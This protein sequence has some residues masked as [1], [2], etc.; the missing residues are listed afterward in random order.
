MKLSEVQKGFFV[1]FR[2]EANAKSTIELYK[3]F[4]GQLT[5]F[6]DDPEIEKISLEDLQEYFNYLLDEYVPVRKN[7]DISPLSGSTLRNHWKAVRSLFHYC[8]KKKF[9]EIDASKD[10]VCPHE[11][12]DVILPLSKKETEAL[13][14]GAVYANQSKPGNRKAFTMRRRTSWRDIAMILLSVDTGLRVGEMSRLHIRDYNHDEQS[15][16]IESYGY[17]KRKTKS[18]V[19]YV[20]DKTA[21]SIWEYL[22]KREC[23]DQNEPLFLGDKG[24][25]V[26]SNSFRCLVADLGSK[27]GIKGVHPNRFRHTFA[28]EFLRNGGNVYT[29][30]AILGHSDLKMCKR[31]LEIARADVAKAQKIHSPVSEWNLG[32]GRVS[33]K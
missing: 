28:I 13:L 1:A 31:Y 27:A 14:Q 26:T 24:D 18:R 2:A 22:A 3:R 32:T 20:S 17:S 7:G 25:G 11:N 23:T 6:L 29:L 21:S 9:V 33:A 16:F 4:L 12:P 30:Q 15:I 10:L 19:L 5:G 8:V